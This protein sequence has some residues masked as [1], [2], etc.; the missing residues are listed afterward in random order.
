MFATGLAG[1]EIMENMAAA[2]SPLARPANIVDILVG[3]LIT[4]YRVDYV[5]ASYGQT[6]AQHCR[7]A[8]HRRAGLGTKRIKP[9]RY[10]WGDQSA[11][12]RNEVNSESTEYLQQSVI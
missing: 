8:L 9:K 3:G 11:T 7:I 2:S 1:R 4:L 6:E 5:R 12:V 10:Y